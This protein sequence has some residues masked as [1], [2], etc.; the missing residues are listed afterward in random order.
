M[1]QQR[2]K[3]MRVFVTGATGF[4]GSAT[5]QELIS[6][7]HQVLGLARTDAGAKSLVAAG[8]QAHRGDLEDLESL[9]AGAAMSDGVIHTA[10]IHDFSKF[11][12][13]CEIDKRAIEALG[14]ALAG[15]NRPLIVTSGTALIAPGRLATEDV[16]APRSGSF[17]RVS[18]QTAESVEGRGVRVSAIRLPPSVHGD[19]DHG[20]VPLLIGLARQKGVSAYVGDG[21]NRWPAVHRLD[22]AHLYRLVLEKGSAGARYHGIADEG[23][24]FRDIAGVIGRRLNL[25]IVAKS[26]EEA[27]DHFGWFAHFAAID[28]PASSQRTQELLGWRPKQPGLIPD[29]D[30]PRYFET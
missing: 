28:A 22:A 2:E 9:R 16:P 20:F 23:V 17:P 24:P 6:A 7:G 14:V 3:Q 30:R 18:E 29:L 5:V 4:V 26:P 15:S 21:L 19:G 1:E 25:P 13:N 8:A 11:A 12:A 27:A 10:F